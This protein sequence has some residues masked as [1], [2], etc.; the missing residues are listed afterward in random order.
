MSASNP[1]ASDLVNKGFIEHRPVTAVP[2]HGG[3]TFIVT[4]LH[5]SGTTLVAS[6]LRHVGIFMGAEINDVVHED[7]AIAKIL[8][9]RD[10]PAL[11]RLIA[12]RNANYGTWGF[13]FPMLCQSLSA[14]DLGLFGDPHVIV[15]FRDPVSVAV[16][17]S[18][19]EY[20]QPV[21]ALRA[22]VDELAETVTFLERLACPQLL[23]SYEKALIFPD[24]FI[25]AILRFCGLPRS[26]ALRQTLIRLIE[27][28][29]R[30]YIAQARRLYEGVVDGITEGC[31]HGWCRLTG[32]D[33]AVTLEL[34][35]DDRPALTVRAD[36]FRQDLLDAGFGTGHHGF[37]AD[38]T[39]T[40]A[41]GGSGHPDEG[42]RP[43]GRTGKQRA[44]R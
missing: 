32:V 12:E 21:P 17:M 1:P 23:L 15:P 4:G 5:R 26:E 31:L 28:N 3:K 22:A 34:L 27:P 36:A 41:A 42:S 24:D 35:V 25:N 37:I 20:H 2:G 7:E 9:A 14:A 19:S 18:L 10:N 40:A 8:T 6:V 11:K 39:Q 44:L 38:L 29:R 30:S 43:G 16:R 13:K 33:D